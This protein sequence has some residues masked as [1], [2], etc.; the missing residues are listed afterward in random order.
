MAATRSSRSTNR[1][2]TGHLKTHPYF[3]HTNPTDWTLPSYLTYIHSADPPKSRD[4]FYWTKGLEDI[5]DCIVK[6]CCDNDKRRRARKLLEEYKARKKQA[7]ARRKRAIAANKATET[8]TTTETIGTVGPNASVLVNSGSVNRGTVNIYGLPLN[9]SIEEGVELLAQLAAKTAEPARAKAVTS[10]VE[11]DPANGYSSSSNESDHHVTA[12]TAERV[13]FIKSYS[14][15]KPE[16]MWT[17]STGRRVERVIYDAVMKMDESSQSV[18]QWFIIDL[19]DTETSR[20]F[21]KAELEEMK[22]VFPA[23]PAP[24]AELHDLIKPFFKTNTLTQL[25]TLLQSTPFNLDSEPSPTPSWVD[26]VLRQT[27]LLFSSPNNL[28]LQQ[29]DEFWYTCRI[30]SH[31]ID[32]C[33]DSLPSVLVSRSEAT[34]RSSAFRLNHT[35]SKTGGAANRQKMGPKLDGIIRT[36]GVDYLELGAIEVAK[37]YD[38]PGATKLL[39]DGRKL[40]GVLRDMLSRLHEEIEDSIVGKVQTVGILNAGLKFQLVRCWGRRKGGVV[41]CWSEPMNEYPVGVEDLGKLWL[42]LKVTVR[43]RQIV[44]EVMEVVGKSSKILTPEDMTKAFF[45]S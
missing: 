3:K 6:R 15:I 16:C 34:S 1:D 7:K 42:L 11:R 2:E 18:L 14:S 26:S 8:T 24:D 13:D 30:W 35:R 9:S 36:S 33:I 45:K 25:R 27:Q 19:T 23:L 37:S 28:L 31:I 12:L 44:Q 39:N 29:H 40:R 17:L 21:S 20:L 32:S 10:K 38:G 22:T 4:L 41:L 43:A 5:A